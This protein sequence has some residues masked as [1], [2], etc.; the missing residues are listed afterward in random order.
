MEGVFGTGGGG[1]WEWWRGYL[2]LDLGFG[3]FALGFGLNTTPFFHSEWYYDANTT[4][5]NELGR[6]LAQIPRGPISNLPNI[7]EI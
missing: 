3:I 2:E 1:I 4:S 7:W 5:E 6:D